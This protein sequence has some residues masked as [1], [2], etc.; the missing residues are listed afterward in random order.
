MVNLDPTIG[1]EIKKIRPCLIVSPSAANKHLLTVLVAP[2]TSTQRRIPTRLPSNINGVEGEI[3]FDQIRSIDKA[4]II[5]KMGILP[6][7]ERV[8]VNTLL[9]EMFSEP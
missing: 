1:A 2:I 3:C 9:H 6:E 4:R 8:K 5:K 7:R